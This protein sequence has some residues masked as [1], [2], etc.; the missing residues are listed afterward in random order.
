MSTEKV[1]ATPRPWRR[2]YQDNQ[3]I[4][5]DYKQIAVIQCREKEWQNNAELIVRAVNSHDALLEACKEAINCII[6]Y[7]NS[8]G[9]KSKLMADTLN[10][11]QQAIK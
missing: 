6:A 1:Q 5:S 7:Q 10:K 2:G 8:W 9:K 11:L 3:V 4:Y